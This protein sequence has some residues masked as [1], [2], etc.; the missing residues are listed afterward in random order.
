M[1][2]DKKVKKLFEVP[3]LAPSD[4]QKEDV[5]SLLKE[6]LASA[7]KGEIQS[8]VAVLIHPDE[9]FTPVT[10]GELTTLTTIGALVTVMLDF[11]NGNPPEPEFIPDQ[12]A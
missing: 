12:G 10:A 8:F 3:P 5:I 1:L 9:K 6:I 4:E 11:Y 2:D 7:E